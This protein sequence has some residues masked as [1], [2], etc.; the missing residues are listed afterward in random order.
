MAATDLIA[1]L[2][3]IQ[4]YVVQDRCA[5]V[6][7]VKQ[8]LFNNVICGLNFSTST[9]CQVPFVQHAPL[10]A[11][12]LLRLQSNIDCKINVTYWDVTHR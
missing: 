7:L 11:A 3:G 2:Q 1:I 4:H 9:Q 8:T 10:T 5:H 6:E 12:T